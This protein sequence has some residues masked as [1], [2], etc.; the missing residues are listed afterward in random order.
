MNQ[1]CLL[2][3]LQSCLSSAERHLFKSDSVNLVLPIL[4]EH[5][6]EVIILRI[7]KSKT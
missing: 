2:I 7:L 3:P 6:E 4:V 5:S 1:Y